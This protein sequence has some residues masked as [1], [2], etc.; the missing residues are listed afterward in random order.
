ML[1]GSFVHQSRVRQV[2]RRRQDGAESADPEVVASA[3]AR[4]AAPLSAGKQ[5]AP[6]S[7]AQVKV[8]AEA[9]H[10]VAKASSS[11]PPQSV[12][13]QA[14]SSAEAAPAAAVSRVSSGPAATAPNP[15]PP[16]LAEVRRL[17]RRKSYKVL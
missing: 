6:L 13:A 4:D 3:P 15:E 17:C 1:P 16:K 8:V 11:L 10:T 5:A 12:A 7:T 14:K 2:Q 9:Q